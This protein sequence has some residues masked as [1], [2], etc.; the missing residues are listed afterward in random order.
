MP[1]ESVTLAEAVAEALS[2]Q[3]SDGRIEIG[4]A[5]IQ[6][7]TSDMTPKTGV[8]GVIT[9]LKGGAVRR[10]RDDGRRRSPEGPRE[11]PR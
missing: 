3:F 10:I 6:A 1:A 2:G 5:D 8:N 11:G 4:P 7:D 9:S